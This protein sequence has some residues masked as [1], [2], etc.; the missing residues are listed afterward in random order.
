MSIRGLL[1]SLLLCGCTLFA[2]PVSAQTG[3]YGKLTVNGLTRDYRLYQPRPGKPAP[4]VLMLHGATGTG[5]QIEEYIGLN[6][7]A[8]RE[9][10]VVAYPNGILRGWHDGRADKHRLATMVSNADDVGFLNRLVDDLIAKGIADP[11]RVYLAGLS[12]GGFMAMRMAC[13][14]SERYA[15]FASLVASAPLDA[16]TTCR[17]TRP[18][19]VLLINGTADTL[20]KFDAVTAARQGNFGA[21]EVAA[22]WGARNGCASFADTALP[23]LDISDRSTVTRRLYSGC[24]AGG[25]T[26]FLTVQGGGHQAPSRGTVRDYPMLAGLL[27]VRNHDI[28]TAETIWSFFQRH[29]R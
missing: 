26:E 8:A 20:V 17:P 10:F 23:D 7:V 19:P 4:L 18:L 29:S 28:D 16:A 13:E 3:S 15:A 27:G 2:A 5:T 1:A 12:N 21:N 25:D 9:G 6:R 24:T 14:S 11:K 22:F